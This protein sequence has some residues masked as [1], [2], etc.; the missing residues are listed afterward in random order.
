MKSDLFAQQEIPFEALDPQRI[1]MESARKQA[2][3]QGRTRLLVTGV[4]FALAFTVLGARL[5]DLAR[6]GGDV[7]SRW[8]SAGLVSQPAPVVTRGDILDRGGNI[9]ATS[10]PTQSLYV[11]PEEARKVGSVKQT[12][13]RLAEGL[14][15][16]DAKK[17]EDTI[18]GPGKFRWLAR[19]LTPEQVWEVNRLGLPGFEFREEEHRVYPHGGMIAHVLGYTDVDGRGMAGIE[20]TFDGRLGGRGEDVRLS[21][22]MRVQSI[23]HEELMAAKDRFQAKGAAGVVMD[24]G[25]GEILAMASLPDFNPNIPA[26][27]QGDAGFNRATMGVYEMGSTFKLFNTAMALDIGKVG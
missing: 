8:T 5:V 2:L 18:N 13:K 17:L 19:N 7:A 16:L 21:L 4:M 3:D 10:L 9:L 1:R 14:P 15:D 23:L 12:A 22:D 11:N 24:V 26:Q 6:H 25:T 27:S 20:R